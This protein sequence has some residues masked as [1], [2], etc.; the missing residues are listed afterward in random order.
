MFI[1]NIK[2]ELRVHGLTRARGKL[3]SEVGHGMPAHVHKYI[4]AVGIGAAGAVA[5]G[6]QFGLLVMKR[7][8][9]NNTPR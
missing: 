3:V 2:A 7:S 6:P 9:S 4:R 1:I 8:T 5:A